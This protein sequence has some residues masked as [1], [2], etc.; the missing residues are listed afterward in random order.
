MTEDYYKILGIS[1]EATDDD[2]KR[3]FR[4]LV[5][6]YHPD[7][8]HAK[9][10]PLEAERQFLKI[11][12]AY[13][14][15]SDREKRLRYDSSTKPGNG[16]VPPIRQSE[17]AR[18]FY[19]DGIK[20][21]KKEYFEKA[22]A[23]FRNAVEIDPDNALYC[24]WLGLSLS[25]QRGHLHDARKWCERATALN[26]SNADYHVN[27]ALV[28]REAGIESLSMKH[29]RKA[30]TIDPSNKRARFWLGRLNKKGGKPIIERIR[31]FLHLR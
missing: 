10:N 11:K 20:A 5:K 23:L 17:K 24:S 2:I 25:K 13:E 3:A 16:A 30:I 8:Q 1:A 29:I 19:H 21:Y 26:P 15:L 18:I 28:Y 9:E 27:L 22:S 7:S 14:T 12:E 6:Q 4:R 31:A